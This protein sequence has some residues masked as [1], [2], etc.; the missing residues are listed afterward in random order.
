M[1]L[2]G[3]FKAFEI[4]G[5]LRFTYLVNIWRW[6][7][8]CNGLAEEYVNLDIDIQCH[9]LDLK[10]INIFNVFCRLHNF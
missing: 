4:M 3:F 8:I 9:K 1:G 7:Q 6:K 5:L 10:W 2:F